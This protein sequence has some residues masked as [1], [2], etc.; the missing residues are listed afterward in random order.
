MLVRGNWIFRVL[1]PAGFVSNGQ[2]RDLCSKQMGDS[3]WD[4]VLRWR[5]DEED[6][7]REDV[8]GLN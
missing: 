7:F 6:K 4:G 3:E 1:E 8:A 2:V 5:M